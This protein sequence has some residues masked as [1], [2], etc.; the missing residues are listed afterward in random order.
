MLSFILAISPIV[1]VL[2]GIM[3]FRKS[4]ARVAPV[5]LIWGMFLALTY[6]NITGLN[7]RE[8]ILVLDAN[9][10]KGI[11]EGF[12]IVVMVF[13]AFTILNSLKDT[14]AMEDVKAAITQASGNDRRVQLI[15]IGI[16]MPI[17]LEGAA[18]AGAPAALVAPF[19][20]ALGFNPLIA[21]AVGALIISIL[22]VPGWIRNRQLRSKHRKEVAELEDN[23]SKYRS[24]LIDAQNSNKDLRQKILE[25]EEA[26]E[27]LEQAQVKAEEEINDLIER[28]NVSFDITNNVKSF[29]TMVGGVL[30]QSADMMI[31]EI[32]EKYGTYENYMEHEY[33]FDEEKLTRLRDL[34]LE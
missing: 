19:L 25:I 31:T 4:A 23:L 18:G 34:Y 17:F 9:L 30:P 6:F 15:I 10:W 28:Y 1:L 22:T 32:L 33:G 24:N 26:K 21:I 8:N 5:A 27:K 2:V 7:L 11:K 3:V 20:T 13:G 14:G 29:L 12:K 16:F